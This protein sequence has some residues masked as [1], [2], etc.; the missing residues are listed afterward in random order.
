MIE[1]VN[2]EDAQGSSIKEMA[3]EIKRK[4]M[5][6]DRGECPSLCECFDD[7]EGCLLRGAEPSDWNVGEEE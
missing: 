2:K 3:R 6:I 5:R 1:L 4:C 7:E